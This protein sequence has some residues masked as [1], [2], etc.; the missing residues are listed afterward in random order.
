MQDGTETAT[1]LDELH[2]SFATFTQ[3][4]QK[5]ANIFLHDVQNGDVVV[6]EGKTLRD[7]ITDVSDQC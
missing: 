6:D 7:Y 1:V 4:K 2:K 3:E 5:Y